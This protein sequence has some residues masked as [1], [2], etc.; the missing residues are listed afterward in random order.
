MSELIANSPLKKVEI[1][2][3]LHEYFKTDIPLSK[4]EGV[5]ISKGLGFTS[6]IIRINLEWKEKNGLPLKVVVKVPKTKHLASVFE[7]L[8][9]EAN[10]HDAASDENTTFIPLIHEKECTAYKLLLVDRP[11]PI[12]KVFG[13]QLVTELS[14]GFIV[15]EDLNER[16]GLVDNIAAD[17]SL[18]QW[19]SMVECLADLHAWSL[20]T[21]IPWREEVEDITCL[22]DVYA[23]CWTNQSAEIQRLK[24]KYPEYF[25]HV[26]EERH[27]EVRYLFMCILHGH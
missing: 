20:T 18:N 10:G 21:D 24:T 1:E 12:P 2:K 8:G 11:I 6:D 15:M 3:I 22:K 9:I 19:Q 5:I 23:K 16:A 14:P 13:Y 4:A 17:I 26:D 27:L 7:R 25:A